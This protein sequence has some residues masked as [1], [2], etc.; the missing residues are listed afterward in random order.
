MKNSKKKLVS[1]AGFTLV[2]LVVTIAVLAILAGVGSVAYSGYIKRAEDAKDMANLANVLT[3]VQSV[4]AA[5]GESVSSI[6]VNKD[7]IVITPSIASYS[8]ASQE[9]FKTL[10]NGIE[11]SK[12]I[13]KFESDTYSSNG[14]TWS[15]GEWKATA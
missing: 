10:T 12:S 3:T 15:D 2:E 11:C 7:G 14:A 9:L 6:V 5:E 1:R 13:I 4:A 8:L